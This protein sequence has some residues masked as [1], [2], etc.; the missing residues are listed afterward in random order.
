MSR[1]DL[2]LPPVTIDYPTSDGKPLAENDPQ[3]HAIH[4]AFGALL[5]RYAAHRDVY[6]SADLLIYYEE[7]NPRAS[8]APDVFVGVGV[9]DRMRGTT[10]SGKREGPGLRAGGGVADTW[11]EAWR[12]SLRCMRDWG[13]GVLPVRPDG[14]ALFAAAAGLPAG[15]RCVRASDGGGVDRPDARDTERGAG[16][17]DVGPGRQDALSRPGDGEDLL[18]HVEE[19]AARG[20]PNVRS[21]RNLGAT[22]RR[23]S[24][25]ERSLCPTRLP[26]FRPS[27]RRW[28]VGP[29]RH[30]SRSWKR[31][32]TERVADRIRRADVPRHGPAGVASS[33]AVI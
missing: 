5:L 10:R 22:D 16:L 8:V 19:H 27:M 7:G 29:P 24:G 30:E 25:R 13:E 3:L 33:G 11:R 18:S 2:P 32:S 14:G 21:S 28:R 23:A 31:A 26:S 15:G 17:E 9:E 6:V 4:Y 20:P 1:P 12:G